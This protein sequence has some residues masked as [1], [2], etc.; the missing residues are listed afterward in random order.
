MKWRSFLPRSLHARMILLTLGTVL[1][2]QAA[3]VASVN[4]FRR[5]FVEEVAVQY[6]ATTISTLRAALA[7]IPDDERAEFVRHASQ[8]Q[9]HLWSRSLPSEARIGRWRHR[10][11][12][13][14]G[15]PPRRE[16]PPM[17]DDMRRDLRLFVRLLN[18]R[19]SDG[20]RVA[21]SRGHRPR[22]FISLASDFGEDDGRRDKEWLV[23]PLDH[24][25]P[26]VA[27]PAIVGWLGV[28]GLFL[29][30]SAV[31]SWHITRPLTRLAFRAAR[32]AG[33][34]PALQRHARRPG[35]VQHRAA[36]PAGRPAP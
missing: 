11:P 28:M 30:I 2:V 21:L 4:Y 14:Q 1:L 24:I 31:F 20:T 35:R 26:P 8:D 7:T 15:R 36:H 9:W 17:P 13:A 10:P 3:T 12:G 19:L 22:M 6:T 29:L 25:A 23:I 18:E 34:G 32:D 33:A 27:T 16:P 5:K